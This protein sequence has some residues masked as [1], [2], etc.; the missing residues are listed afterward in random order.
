MAWLKGPRGAGDFIEIDEPV[1]FTND[2]QIS[3]ISSLWGDTWYVDGD[4]GLTTN[5]GK[6]PDTALSTIGAA[7]DLAGDND[8]IIVKAGNIAYAEPGLEITQD[9]LRLIGCQQHP[10]MF[11]GAYISGTTD[12]LLKVNAN[13]VEIAG[14]TFYNAGDSYSAVYWAENTS[15][16]QGYIHD[17]SFHGVNTGEYGIYNEIASDPGELVIQH[18]YFMD[19]DTAAINY[20]SSF[21]V[22]EDCIFEV[23][24]GKIGIR[25]EATAIGNRP[26]GKIINNKFFTDDNNN[27]VGISFVATPGVG[28]SLI[29]GNHFQNFAD[30]AHCISTVNGYTGLNWNQEIVITVATA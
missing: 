29:D 18:C 28:H 15:T 23:P 4:G 19:Y 5:T 13:A 16:Y 7:L 25:Y 20:Y 14:L 11:W 9:G 21:G 6:T 10:G 2:V 30:D 26:W 3:K 8:T 12:H 22:I 17:C 1:R 27:A 24:T